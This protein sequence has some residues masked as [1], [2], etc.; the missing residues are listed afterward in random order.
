MS[1]KTLIDRPSRVG[2]ASEPDRSKR[3]G[4]ASEPDRLKRVGRDSEPDRSKSVGRV[5]EPDQCGLKVHPP[6]LLGRSLSI[7]FILLVPA[8]ASSQQVSIEV[9]PRE[10]TVGDPI[11]MVL[12]IHTGLKDKV[13]FPGQDAL[14]PAEIIRIDTINAKNGDW[15]MRYIISL[16]EPGDKDLPELPVV[17]QSAGGTDTV[18]VEPGNIYVKSVLSPEDSLAGLKDIKPP[19]PLRWTFQDLL[20]WLIVAVA[21]ILAFIAGWYIR[22]KIK[23]ARG[24]IPEYAPPSRPAHLVALERLE[25]LKAGGLPDIETVLPYYSELSE[26]L[27]EYIGRRF[28]IDALEMTTT[29]LFAQDLIWS[30]N[31]ENRSHIVKIMTMSD[32]VKFARFKPERGDHIELLEAGFTYVRTT[33]PEESIYVPVGDKA[34]KPAALKEAVQ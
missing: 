6:S 28:E 33:K 30:I 21:L 7:L 16:F 12:N 8:F 20:P 10:I 24:E 27:K 18:W 31:R 9:N 1:R 11:E 29:E 14:V 23:R 25:K 3:V 4:R 2:R 15:S 22:R 5:S 19:I 32:L 17:V 34:A 13:V 26:I